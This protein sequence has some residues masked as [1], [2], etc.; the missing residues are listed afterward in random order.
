M[1]VESLEYSP[2][3]E[4]E[5][6]IGCSQLC[7]EVWNGKI[8]LIDSNGNE[9]SYLTEA[10]INGVA[11]AGDSQK[12]ILLAA[13]DDFTLSIFSKKTNNLAFQ[14]KLEGHDDLVTSLFSLSPH[15]ALTC[16]WDKTIRQWD[17][18]TLQNTQIIKGFS[19]LFP[20]IFILFQNYFKKKGTL[21]E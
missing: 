15:T 14:S 2:F 19:L 6:L 17:L 13:S 20:Q 7:G 3:K 5:L 1:Y 4:G 18:S 10:G 12:P 9:L 16:S 11:W 8:V 21:E